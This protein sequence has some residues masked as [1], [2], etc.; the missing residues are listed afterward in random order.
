LRIGN[1]SAQTESAFTFSRGTPVAITIY[2]IAE[3]AHVSIAT[4]SRVF[5]NHPRVQEETRRRVVEVARSLG[6]Q[7]HVSAR[8]LARQNTNLISAVVPMMTSYFFM[9]VMRGFQDRMEESAFDLLV[10]ASRTLDNVDSQLG[11]ALQKGRADG[12]LL[13]STPLTSQRVARLKA[14]G[15]PLVLVDSHHPDFDSISVDNR[16]GGYEA[17]RHLIESGRS[18]IGLIMADPRSVPAADRRSGYVEAHVEAGRQ[19]EDAFTWTAEEP[20]MHGY[21]KETG[22]VAMKALLAGR[23]RPDAV[24]VASDVQALGAMRA[25]REAGL[26]VPDD[27]AIVGFDDIST[28]AFVGLTTLRQPMYEMGKLAVEKLIR[29]VEEP[30]RPTSHT[31][32]SPRLVVRDSCGSHARGIDYDADPA[33]LTE[34][35]PARLA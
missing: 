8:S 4:V 29:R 16:K 34:P 15:C 26:R 1:I 11:R 9:E 31:T 12:T 27:M 30:E 17:T 6:Y 3:K 20:R 14:S 33:V 21:D 22:Y 25:I 10:F 28:S 13:C 35:V 23:R 5:N 19:V 7:P 24:F 18:R 32:F 2:D